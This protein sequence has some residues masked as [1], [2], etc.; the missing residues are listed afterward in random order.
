VELPTK[1][2]IVAAP[3]A[4]PSDMEAAPPSERVELPVTTPAIDHVR[5]GG[6]GSLRLGERV[7]DEIEPDQVLVQV[8]ATS[9]NPADWY[10]VEGFALARTGNGLR[11]PKDPQVGIDLAGRVAAVGRDVTAL[12]VGD[13]V[14][15]S[16]AGAWA[17]LALA[18]E[19]RLARKP[20]GVSY[21][22]AAAVPVAAVTALQAVR[23]HAGVTKGARVLV[24]GASG[25]VG[26]FAVQIARWLGADVTAVCSTANVETARSLGAE[27]V[28]DYREQDFCTLGERY[29]AV[30]DIAGSRPY[31]SLRRV[32]EP[33]ACVVLV[34]APMTARGLG[35]LPH[36]VATK[37]SGLLRR[38]PTAFFVAKVNTADLDLLGRLLDEGAIRVVTDSRFTGLDQIPDALSH[39]GTGHARGKIVVTV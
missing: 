24:N 13:A 20:D 39:L 3:Q 2:A 34:G 8:E 30:I 7:I 32:L 18:R 14:F 26:P 28:V 19:A 21:E 33:N 17:A 27:R 23:D 25:G 22:D 37:V 38:R 29:D 4:P 16:G 31:R 15:G 10:G 1:E 5:Y 9:V 12:R 11:T 36:L 35:P 6:R